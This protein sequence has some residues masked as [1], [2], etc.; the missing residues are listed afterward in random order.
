[1]FAKLSALV[2]CTSLVSALTIMVPDSSVQ[3]GASVNL[4][5]NR[6]EDDPQQFSLLLVSFTNAIENLFNG[7]Y[8]N[9]APN[10]TVTIPGGTSSGNYSIVAHK[11]DDIN[12]PPLAS[13]NSFAVILNDS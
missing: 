10:I 4:T 7:G 12:G 1:M 2:L 11:V 8:A 6:Y 5:L 13:S 3:A 9:Y